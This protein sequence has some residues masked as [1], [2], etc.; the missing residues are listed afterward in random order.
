MGEEEEEEASLPSPSTTTRPRRTMRSA[1]T[2]MTS[3]PILRWL[4]K[5]GGLGKPMDASGSSQLIMLRCGNDVSEDD[6]EVEVEGGR[7]RETE[8]ANIEISI[9]P[10]PR[11]FLK[12]YF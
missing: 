4:T 12:I 2:P 6:V 8:P 3:Y 7:R 11:L 1:S 9:S 10:C 5:A